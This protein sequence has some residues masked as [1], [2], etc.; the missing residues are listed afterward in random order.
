MLH[1][2][3]LFILTLCLSC[4]LLVYVSE[5][6]KCFS[7]ASAEKSWK[8]Y[9][10]TRPFLIQI[11]LGLSQLVELITINQLN[12]DILSNKIGFQSQSAVRLQNQMSSEVQVVRVMRAAL[13][14]C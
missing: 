11:R 1:F 2:A 12:H 7:N 4:L 14:L 13:V 8:G 3:I 9:A 6:I 10:A 5:E